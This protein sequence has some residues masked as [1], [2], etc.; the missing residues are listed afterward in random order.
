[1]SIKRNKTE[2]PTRTFDLKTKSNFRMEVTISTQSLL[3]VLDLNAKRDMRIDK[4]VYFFVPDEVINLSAEEICKN[5][6]DEE[7]ILIKEM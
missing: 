5:H 1:M 6:L 3:D 2:Y 4:Q 7:M